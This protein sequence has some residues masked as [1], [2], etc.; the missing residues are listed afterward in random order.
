[1]NKSKNKGRLF[2]ITGISG[3]GKTTLG[4]KIK[5]KIEL[6]YGPTLLINGDDLRNIFKLEG[7][8]YNERLN[9]GYMYLN[10]L[11]LI[12]SQNINVIFTVVGLFDKLRKQNRKLFKNY[13]EIFIDA[14]INK[15][16]KIKKKDTYKNKK[17]IW[18]VDIKPQFPKKPHIKINNNFSK[19]LNQLSKMLINEILR[20]VKK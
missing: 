11:K 1:M 9:I 14:D 18:G 4:K 5:N 15:V 20:K 12:T 16:I 6:H 2:W 3:A 13:H 17:N 8:S 7:Y 19:D 10:F